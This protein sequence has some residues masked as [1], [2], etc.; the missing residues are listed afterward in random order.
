[1]VLQVEALAAEPDD[2][3][4][5]PRPHRVNGENWHMQVVLWLPDMCHGMHVPC[6]YRRINELI[7]KTCNWR[8]SS[9]WRHG[10]FSLVVYT[11]V[12]GLGRVVW[13]K[14]GICSFDLCY[15]CFPSSIECPISQ[16]LD[17]PATRNTEVTQFVIWWSGKINT[18]R[19]VFKYH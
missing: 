1:M 10:K 18:S 3:S 16:Q 2:L 19:V 8:R 9:S 13:K 14:I 15:N 11:D 17:V 4:L 5:T 12:I 6:V 7:K